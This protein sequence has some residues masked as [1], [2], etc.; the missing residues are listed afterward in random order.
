MNVTV[1]PVT[2][3]SDWPVA[4]A[5]CATSLLFLIRGRLQA[6]SRPLL[7]GDRSLD[8]GGY[9]EVQSAS[10]VPLPPP[11]FSNLEVGGLVPPS[12]C[13]VQTCSMP[14]LMLIADS[15]VLTRLLQLTISVEHLQEVSSG[16]VLTLLWQ[17]LGQLLGVWAG[18]VTW[19]HF[20]V[21]A[22]GDHR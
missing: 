3:L 20:L 10:Q 13:L 15:E 11:S 8:H 12:E 1:M 22:G 5:G 18:L 4:L 16:S 14:G 6:P 7:H 9:K 19:V 2:L 17:D 21:P